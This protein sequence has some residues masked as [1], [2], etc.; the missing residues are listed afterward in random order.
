[1]SE[2]TQILHQIDRGDPE[3]T[4]QLLPLVY[5][6]LKKLA[7]TKMLVERP[8][9]TLQATALVHEAYL[10]LINAQQLQRW[11]SRGH[12]FAAAAEAMRRILIDHA[13]KRSARK[14]GGESQRVEAEHLAIADLV[15][16]DL[17][18]DVDECITR[19]AE[20]DSTLAQFVKLRLFAGFS[21]TEV[22]ELLGMPRHVAYEDWKYIRTWIAANYQA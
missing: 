21:V 14:R 5:E 9:H 15:D 12:F 18:I 1:M 10:R 13:R 22:G 7:A 2:V 11:D 19:L 17:L 20:E 6:E 4:E 16:Y 3:A 8:N